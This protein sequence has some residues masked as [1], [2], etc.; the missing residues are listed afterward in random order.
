MEHERKVIFEIQKNYKKRKFS[1]LEKRSKLKDLE[2]FQALDFQDLMPLETD[3]RKYINKQ[4][5]KKSH[6]K[7]FEKRRKESRISQSM[8]VENEEYRVN[9]YEI[10]KIENEY[11]ICDSSLITDDTKSNKSGEKQSLTLKKIEEN[12]NKYEISE[13][14]SKNEVVLSITNFSSSFIS[15]KKDEVTKIENIPCLQSQNRL[16]IPNFLQDRNV[17]KKGDTQTRI[18]NLNNY[19]QVLDSETRDLYF[20][21]IPSNKIYS[22]KF[23]EINSSD[24]FNEDIFFKFD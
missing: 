11:N 7:S 15:Q 23:S 6:K 3:L 8:D 24:N 14:S 17:H 12:I 1:L 9:F 2:A 5:R 16:I 4:V 22:F 21:P 10:K 19:G 18:I 20:L 13:S